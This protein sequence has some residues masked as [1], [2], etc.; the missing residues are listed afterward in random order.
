[1]SAFA[2]TIEF[3]APLVGVFVGTLVALWLDRHNENRRKQLRAE[4]LLK[5]LLNEIQENNRV[6]KQIKPAFQREKWGK[7]F[8]L[9]TNAWD[10]AVAGGDL[11]DVIG[12]EVANQLSLHYGRFQKITYYVDLLTRL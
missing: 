5:S 10:T 8:Y 9:S 12:V 4:V 7:T 6:I 1:M 2:I 11:A 3:A